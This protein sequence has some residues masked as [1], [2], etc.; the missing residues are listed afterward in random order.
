MDHIQRILGIWVSPIKSFESFPQNINPIHWLIP[1][2]LIIAS[3]SVSTYI[4]APYAK[5]LQYQMISQNPNIDEDDKAELLSG[6]E[7]GED[8]MGMIMFVMAAG[9]AMIWYLMQSGI[10]YGI[11]TMILGVTAPFLSFWFLVLMV[12][13]TTLVEMLIKVPLIIS[14]NSLQV[15][16]GL[17]LLIP[18]SLTESFIYNFMFQFDFFS[19]WRVV[20]LG[21]GMSIIFQTEKKKTLGILFGL[22][23]A[24]ALLSTILLNKSGFYMMR[25]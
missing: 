7:D 6:F 22:W 21:L 5:D 11:G 13:T 3:L 23:V 2:I 18:D 14:T 9:G 19:I 10:V 15:E 12:N 17:S 4:S 8:T 16:T 20:L 1:L 25:G 24:Y